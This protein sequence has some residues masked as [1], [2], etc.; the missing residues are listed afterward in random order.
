ML[1]WCD[2]SY[3]EDQD[4]WWLSGIHRHVRLLSKPAALA[5]RDFAVTTDVADG[6]ATHRLERLRKRRRDESLLVARVHLVEVGIGAHVHRVVE[7]DARAVVVVRDR[8]A[9]L[10]VDARAQRLLAR[11][12]AALPQH[13]GDQAL[14]TAIRRRLRP[15]YCR[16]A[17]LHRQHDR[18]IIAEPFITAS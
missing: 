10:G 13:A 5:I 3:L 4:T 7:E 14:A 17:R 12:V 16:T 8:A 15:F 9:Q 1:R 11:R 2:G 6:G 18:R